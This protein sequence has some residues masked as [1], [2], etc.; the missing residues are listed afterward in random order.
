[1][2]EAV[3]AACLRRALSRWHIQDLCCATRAAR[4]FSLHSTWSGQLAARWAMHARSCA[5]Q[6]AEWPC[7]VPAPRALGMLDRTHLLDLEGARDTNKHPTFGF[8]H[9]H[10]R[11]TDRDTRDHGIHGIERLMKSSRL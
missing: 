4:L 8:A 5:Q 9:V 7:A 6:E 11:H 10:T 1:M 2:V 3:A